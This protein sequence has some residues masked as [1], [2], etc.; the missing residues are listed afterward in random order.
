MQ[1]CL[2]RI[3]FPNKIDKLFLSVDDLPALTYTQ[4]NKRTKLKQ[5]LKGGGRDPAFLFQYKDIIWENNIIIIIGIKHFMGSH[6][7]LFI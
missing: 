6:C 4:Y 3:S 5:Q 7:Q 2:K 1:I